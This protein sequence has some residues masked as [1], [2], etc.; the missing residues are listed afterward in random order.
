MWGICASAL[1]R[2]SRIAPLGL[3]T[4]SI[5]AP[6]Y[7]GIVLYRSGGNALLDSSGEV[8]EACTATGATGAATGAALQAAN[9]NMHVAASAARLNKTS[10]CPVLINGGFRFLKSVNRSEERR[11]V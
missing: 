1:N 2:I 6:G 8:I 4:C 11:V 5:L 9:P 3:R 7:I 10:R